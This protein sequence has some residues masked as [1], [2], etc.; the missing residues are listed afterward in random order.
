MCENLFTEMY[1]LV[2][3]KIDLIGLVSLYGQLVLTN[4]GN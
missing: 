4:A 1:F 2:K 3:K